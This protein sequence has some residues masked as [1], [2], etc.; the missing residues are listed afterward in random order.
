M[1]DRTSPGNRARVAPM[2][3][4]AAV[5]VLAIE[6][7]RASGPIE[8]SGFSAGIA[9]AALISLS[10]YLLPGVFVGVLLAVA[11]I[12]RTSDGTR[13]AFPRATLI[14]VIL[15]TASRVVLQFTSIGGAYG[16]GIA[17][18]GLAVGTLILA[19]A[20]VSARTGAGGQIAVGIFTGFALFSVVA[21]VNTSWDPIWR[22]GLLAWVIVIFEVIFALLAA[23]YA[24]TLPMNLAPS[25]RV[26]VLGPFFALATMTFANPAFVSSELNFGIGAAT[27]VIAACACLGIATVIGVG[28]ALPEDVPNWL[29]PTGAGVFAASIAAS[30][31]GPGWLVLLAVVASCVSGALLLV[32]AL[33][34]PPQAVSSDSTTSMTRVALTFAGLAAIAGLSIVLTHLIYQLDYDQ[35]LPFNNVLIP[36]ASAIAL[37]VGA[38]R[39]DGHHD[40]AAASDE[41]SSANEALGDSPSAKQRSYAELVR[42][43]LPAPLGAPLALSIGSLVVVAALAALTAPHYISPSAAS[44]A[45]GEIRVFDWNLHYSVSQEPGVELEEIA[46]AI[47]KSGA[48]VVT[49][50]ELNRGWTFGG[51]TDTA[52]WLSRRLGMHYAWAPAAD[53][54]FG[55]IILSAYELRD[56]HVIELPFG[57][58]PQKRSAITATITVGGKDVSVTSVHLQHRNENTP[59]RTEQINTLL[60]AV[61]SK[62]PSII[63]GDMNSYPQWPEIKLFTDAGFTSG[64]DQV[65][66]PHA[67]T[68]PAWAPDNRIDYVFGKGVQFNSFTM[69]TSLASDHLSLLVSVTIP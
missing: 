58:G 2:A 20:T 69:G 45:T 51:G 64:Q 33:Y 56:P 29:W 10:M 7:I 13:E 59:T 14:A 16:L 32:L 65:G 11:A 57:Q 6:L 23:W 40:V 18:V 9:T 60:A 39:K 31:W 8:D 66:D 49:L 22:T 35:P 38:L 55:N 54:Q 15:L 17:A 26:W 53:D 47:E 21:I 5:T 36:V 19:A 52:E 61:G 28:R 34:P 3:L 67:M 43:H 41:N 48:Q 1:S 24:R 4:M 44:A 30:F 46:S 42:S 63:G 50:Q 68:S 27:V 12:G 62:T 25:K 37:G